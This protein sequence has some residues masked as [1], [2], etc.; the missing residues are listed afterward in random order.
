MKAFKPSVDNLHLKNTMVYGATGT[1]K[2]TIIHD[3]LH[4][5]KDKIP[6][7]VIFSSTAKLNGAYDGIAPGFLVHDIIDI[8]KLEDIIDTQE[9]KVKIYNNSKDLDRLHTLFTKVANS[10]DRMIDKQIKELS[11]TA[12]ADINMSQLPIST[13]KQERA[14]LKNL[15][16]DRLEQLYKKCIRKH[17]S[18][19]LKMKI[20][21]DD[22]LVIKFLDMNPNLLIVFD[23][24]TA[25]FTKSFQH[26][27]VIEKI[28]TQGR[29]LMITTAVGIHDDTKI[30]TSVRK[31]VH[32]SIFTTPNC[33]TSFFNNKANSFTREDKLKFLERVNFIFNNQDNDMPKHTKLIYIR[34]PSDGS[35]DYVQSYLAT[36]HDDFRFGATEY[37]E[38][39][40]RISKKSLQFLH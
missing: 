2:T 17:R 25:D 38:I 14:R 27:K 35:D 29:W 3:A 10:N 34:N 13:K 8:K 5:L 18:L 21:Q 6:T 11:A 31:G 15:V 39:D 19:L 40:A 9:K 33:A 32:N 23:D 22:K 7:I 37:W 36:E 12:Y 24:V 30:D 1:G 28:Y 26:E 4:A 20:N 16:S